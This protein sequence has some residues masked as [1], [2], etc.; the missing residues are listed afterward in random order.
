MSVKHIKDL[1]RPSLGSDPEIMC[2]SVEEKK[3]VS[4]IP[5]LKRDKNNP[6]D[7]GDGIKMYADNVLIEASFPPSKNRASMV[8]LMRTVF[9]RMQEK[10]GDK[11]RLLPKAAHVYS[12]KELKAEYGIDPMIGGCDPS[13]NVYRMEINDIPNFQGGLRSGSF[14]IHLGHNRLLDFDTRVSAVKL[15]DIFLGCSSVIFD[16]DETAL[17][18]RDLYGKASEHRMP[19]HGVEYRC[20]GP[21]SLR[22]PK[23]TALVLDLADYALESLRSGKEL[24]IINSVDEN[25]VQEAINT[26]NPVL[27]K[28]VLVQA[29]MSGE[30]MTR[31]E[32]SYK[33]DFY[34]DWKI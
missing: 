34:K 21:W 6:I 20:L 33:P 3:I 28:K 8:K 4:S 9:T 16:K 18:R 10:L 12:N 15:L 13:F 30:L 14:H 22:S 17:N 26:C 23:T 25:N 11:Y 24:D 27:A 31:V 19:P 1:L 2:Y 5:V 32:A 7:L 29:G